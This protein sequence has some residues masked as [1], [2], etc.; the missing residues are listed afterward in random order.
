MNHILFFFSSLILHPSSF[1]TPPFA[2][3]V[4]LARSAQVNW[5]RSPIKQRLRHV[6]SLR[7]L[8]SRR[9]DALCEAVGADIGRPAVEVLATELLPSAAALKFLEQRAERVLAPHRVGWGLIPVWLMGCR[10][11]IH[12]RAWG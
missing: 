1:M 12:R 8:I 10:D 6:R 2:D 7:D 9:A 4:A 5:S 11:E 3:E